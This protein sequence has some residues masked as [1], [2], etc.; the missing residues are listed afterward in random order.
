LYQNHHLQ[1]QA[2]K[3]SKAKN[4]SLVPKNE[5]QRASDGSGFLF[6]VFKEPAV[7]GRF[8][9]LLRTAGHSSILFKKSSKRN[10]NPSRYY[11]SITNLKF[12]P[13]PKYHLSKSSHK[14]RPITLGP[15]SIKLL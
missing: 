7:Q 4:K 13:K 15:K 2:S 8:F 9:D 14:N 1:F 10:Q 6:K 3:I 12:Q 11:N 5:N